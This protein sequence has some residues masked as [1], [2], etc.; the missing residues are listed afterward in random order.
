[1]NLS[2]IIFFIIFITTNF[3][4]KTQVLYRAVLFIKHGSWLTCNFFSKNVNGIL[5]PILIFLTQNT[6]LPNCRKIE[7]MGEIK[8]IFQVHVTISSVFKNFG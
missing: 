8:V 5:I 2:T 7:S 1:M 6:I 4:R 3:E